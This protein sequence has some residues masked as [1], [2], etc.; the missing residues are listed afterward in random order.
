M[1]SP[2]SGIAPRTAAT[3]TL[4]A[5]GAC[6]AWPHA[7]ANE[8][9]RRKKDDPARPDVEAMVR[10][11]HASLPARSGR[12]RGGARVL[13]LGGG[14]LVGPFLHDEDLVVLV[15]ASGARATGARRSTAIVSDLVGQRDPCRSGKSS[16]AR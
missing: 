15:E 8:G 16:A 2:L 10:A 5:D 13:A 9:D 3:Y 4:R 7:K 6:S 14:W 12:V 11:P 1:T